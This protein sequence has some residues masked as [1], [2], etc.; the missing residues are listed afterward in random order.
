MA[1]LEADLTEPD[2][3]LMASSVLATARQRCLVVLL[4]DL[5]PAAMTE[6]LLPRIGLLATRHRLLIGAVADPRVAEMAAA[7]GSTGAV[8]RPAR[9][10]ARRPAGRASAPS[11]G[12]AAPRWW[13]RRPAGCRRRWPT[14]IWR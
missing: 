11:S 3:G 12:G 10:P 5:N 1:L 2:Y 4:T 9:R 7:R 14:L 8:Y 6:G 13:T